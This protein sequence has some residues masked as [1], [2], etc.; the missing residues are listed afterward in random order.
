MTPAPA[1]ARDHPALAGFALAY[2]IGFSA[3]AIAAGNTEGVVYLIAI[4]LAFFGVVVVYA[5]VEIAPGVLWGLSI[6]GLLHMAGG[7]VRVDGEVLYGFQ[8]IPVALRFDQA[9]HALGF[10]FA[11]LAAWQGLR[12]WIRA[13]RKM[14]GGLCCLIALMG[15]GV[16]AANEVL[17][18][19]VTRVS[20]STNV[21]GYENTGWD[22]V[23][24]TF[25][26]IAATLWI[27]GR[28]SKERGIDPRL[29]A[30]PNNAG[31]RRD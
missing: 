5:H 21:G 22:L 11:T 15:M 23:F 4:S 2:L 25:G 20:D 26:A 3:V 12:P 31:T 10:G 28:E 24:N 30:I 17:E 29:G 19:A 8:L 14:T 1:L 7:L 6:W 27:K 9:V 13:E 18:F 16:G